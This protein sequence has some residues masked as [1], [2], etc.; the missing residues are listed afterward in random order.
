M[1]KLRKVNMNNLIVISRQRVIPVLLFACAAL[2][3]FSLMLVSKP[4]VSGC[5]Y[6][7]K[8]KIRHLPSFTSKDDI[9]KDSI[10]LGYVGEYYF[11][12]SFFIRITK[13]G[14]QLF[15]QVP[16][17]NKQEIIAEVNNKFVLK[18]T[19]VQITFMKDKLGLVHS[20]ILYHH[21]Q[22]ME[23]KRASTLQCK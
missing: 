10:L 14:H 19:N 1:E 8:G 23:G 20:I 17:G 7:E 21:G 3:I 13:E 5:F 16:R 15:A 6:G 18:G 4:L 9:G 12:P 2:P 22:K 11:S